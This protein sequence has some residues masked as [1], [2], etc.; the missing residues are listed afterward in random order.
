MKTYDNHG[1]LLNEQTV[2]RTDDGK[3]IS[4]NTTYDTY[5]GR[6]LFQNIST[7]DSQGKVTT[8]NVQ[9]GTILP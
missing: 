6:P 1:N 4:T 7:R 5:T 3:T 2:S 9:N 8:S